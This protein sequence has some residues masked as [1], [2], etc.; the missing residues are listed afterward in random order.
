MEN[1]VAKII[2]SSEPSKRESYTKRISKMSNRV[3]RSEVKRQGKLE[4]GKSNY[5]GVVLSVILEAVLSAHIQKRR[6]YPA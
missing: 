4:A 2:Q 5:H 1:E 3:L 6:M